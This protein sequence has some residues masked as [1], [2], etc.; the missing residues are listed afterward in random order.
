M[1]EHVGLHGDGH[2]HSFQGAGGL[3]DS[4]PDGETVHSFPALVTFDVLRMRLL[5][6]IPVSPINKHPKG[7]F[8]VPVMA[9]NNFKGMLKVVK[10]M[11]CIV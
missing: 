2:L 7:N 9:W 4:R 6:P 3:M 8:K 11:K 10:L 1:K 5:T